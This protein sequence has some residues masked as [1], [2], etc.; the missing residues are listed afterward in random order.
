V[1]V[2]EV[3]DV[4][5][6][7]RLALLRVGR[8]LRSRRAVRLG[9]L[10]L[11][12][13]LG[14]VRVGARDRADL[15]HQVQEVGHAPVLG[16]LAVLDPEEPVRGPGS[17]LP[18]GRD[19]DEVAL[20]GPAPDHARGDDVALGHHLLDREV[21]VG[22]RAAEHPR[23]HLHALEPLRRAGRTA[24]VDV[25]LREQL[26]DEVGVAVVDDLLDEPGVDLFVLLLGQPNPPP[27]SSR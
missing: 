18:A 14:R 6:H 16:D 27:G 13:G 4:V 8:Q 5:A 25:A 3:A 11:G 7:D 19:A 15:L 26:G 9:S 22:E 23:D 12:I 1:L 17:P 10:P 2:E 20:V 21:H 24:V